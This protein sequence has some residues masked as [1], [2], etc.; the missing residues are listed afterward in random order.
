MFGMICTVFS[1]AAMFLAEGSM[2]L[3][4]ILAMATE[5]LT[6]V[7][8]SMGSIL[9]FVTHNPLILIFLI[10]TI[11]GFA[12]GFLMRIWHGVG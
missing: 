6:W 7:I 2:S 3:Q 8:S 11:V 10:M 4:D 1:G 9:T 5:L 12:V